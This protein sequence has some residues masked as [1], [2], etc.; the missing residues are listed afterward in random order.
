[1]TS[2]HL[3]L[4]AVVACAAPTLLPAQLSIPRCANNP[5]PKPGDVDSLVIQ[6]GRLCAMLKTAATVPAPAPVPAPVPTPLPPTPVPAPV[7]APPVSGSHEPAGLTLLASN[8]FTHA[9]PV[10]N[11]GTYPGEAPWGIVNPNGLASV[12]PGGGLVYTYRGGVNQAGGSPATT[13][14]D[15]SPAPH[16]LYMRA[17]ITVSSPYSA[18]Q[19]GHNKLLYL[20]GITLELLTDRLGVTTSMP[21][22]SKNYVGPTPFAFGV[23]HVVEWLVDQPTGKTQF[24]LDGIDQGSFPITFPAG[25]SAQEPKLYGGYDAT[26]PAATFTITYHDVYVSGTP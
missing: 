25:W 11:D 2:R 5:S 6:R 9:P 15:P 20:G 8:S 7:P 14:F 12:A 10:Q 1:M 24:W 22:D 3:L 4:C 13:Y 21:A 18:P 26:A 17:T 16:T 23:P 19:N